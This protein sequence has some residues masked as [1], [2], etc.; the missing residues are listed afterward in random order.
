MMYLTVLH[1]AVESGLSD[2]PDDSDGSRRPLPA[3]EAFDEDLTADEEMEDESLEKAVKKPKAAKSVKTK[4]N[5]ATRKSNR[6]VTK[7]DYYE[8]SD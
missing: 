4:A 6:K 5:A 2:K 7:T 3:K 8:Y 1:T